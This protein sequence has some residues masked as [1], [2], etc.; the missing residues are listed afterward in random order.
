[1]IE[2]ENPATNGALIKKTH[3]NYNITKH[4]VNR[5]GRLTFA[6][7]C[8]VTS[9]SKKGN[10][11]W[12]LCPSHQDNNPSLRID[13]KDDRLLWKC[14]AGCSQESV[15]KA[16]LNLIPEASPIERFVK[17]SEYI[18]QNEHGADSLRVERLESSS[19][20][21]FIQSHLES[22]RWVKGGTT[23]LLRPYKYSD[24]KSYDRISLV[25]GEKCA[26]LIQ[27]LG[28]PA[29]CIPGGASGW[30]AHYAKF[31]AGKEVSIFPDN[32]EPG[33]RFGQLALKDVKP[34]A[35]FAKIVRLPGLKAKEDVADWIAQGNTAANLVEIISNSPEASSA[36]EVDGVKELWENPTE[37]PRK[38][39]LAPEHPKHLLPGLV[40]PWIMDTCERMQVPID[41]IMTP[42]LVA[43]G[44]LLSRRVAIQPKANDTWIIHANLWG[45]IIG[46]PSVL[47]SPALKEGTY[48]IEKHHEDLREGAK[49]EGPKVDARR[50]LLQSKLKQIIRDME[51]GGNKVQASKTQLTPEIKDKLLEDEYQKISAELNLLRDPN[52][53]LFIGDSSYQYVCEALRDNPKGLLI[54]RDELSGFISSLDEEFN[55]GAK[56]FYLEA[57]N[58]NGTFAQGRVSRGDLHIRGLSVS[59]LGGIQPDKLRRMFKDE[60]ELGEANDGFLARFQVLTWPEVS[61]NWRY[62]DRPPSPERSRITEISRRILLSNWENICQ[63]KTADGVPLMGFSAGAQELFVSWLTN[64]QLRLQNE[65]FFSPLFESVLGKYR[66]L[67]PALALI[68]HFLDCETPGD[69]ISI[70]SARFAAEY[71]DYLETHARKI[72]CRDVVAGTAQLLLS[73]IRSKKIVNGFTVRDISNNGWVGLKA[74]EV[75]HEGLSMLES[76]GYLKLMVRGSG[77]NGGR[78]TE[79]IN[80]N[81]LIFGGGQ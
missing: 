45:G 1:M 53:K 75:I 17:V 7:V 72:F 31:F 3:K 15:L 14:L 10:S 40:S 50:A 67:M 27:S 25:E 51:P 71:C 2:K 74:S 22:G 81:P 19:G 24:W 8:E 43:M 56:S 61:G 23:E 54:I 46:K 16:L 35:K 11:Y 9:A 69:E 47:K 33:E 52:P 77:P 30:K 60:F 63:R 28:I 6:R 36:I 65:V 20:K 34:L 13:L 41:F 38:E 4:Q 57:W 80:L 44:S 68:H 39:I 70:D 49:A 37:L 76:H 42:C 32:D 78:P 18:Y 5:Q 21:R 64:H 66:K 29:T 62:V 26:E 59:V 55:G 12:G 58:G 79:E 73:K 48:F